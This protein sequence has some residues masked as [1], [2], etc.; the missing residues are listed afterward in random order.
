MTRKNTSLLMLSSI[1][2]PSTVLFIAIDDSTTII[3]TANRSSTIST[4]NTIEAN[5]FCLRFMSVK[6]LMIIVVD[7]MESIPPRKSELIIVKPSS[8]PM[9]KPVAIMPST[10]ISAVTTAEPPVLT[11]FLKLN[12]SPSEKRSTTIPICA[13]NSMLASVVTDGRAVKCG[14]ARNPAT[15]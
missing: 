8:L 13:Q 7:D 3:T 5:F 12:S 10:I 1:S 4:A 15:M 11:S 6:A 2:L 14:D 9:A